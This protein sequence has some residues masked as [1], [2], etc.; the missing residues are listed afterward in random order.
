MANIS[1]FL[2]VL[3]WVWLATFDRFDVSLLIGQLSDDLL[4][5]PLTCSVPKKVK[6]KGIRFI[7]SIPKHIKMLEKLIRMREGFRDRSQI[8]K[9]PFRRMFTNKFRSGRIMQLH[10]IL[11]TVLI[12]KD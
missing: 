7:V 4:H 1:K 9:A 3:T 5:L 11:Q 8:P 2:S 12:V 6:G 10:L